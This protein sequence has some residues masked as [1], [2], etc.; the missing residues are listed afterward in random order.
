MAVESLDLA[1]TADSRYALAK[2]LGDLSDLSGDRRVYTWFGGHSFAVQ[3]DLEPLR[4]IFKVEGV[5]ISHLVDGDPARISARQLSLFRDAETDGF[6]SRWRNPFTT[7]LDEITFVEQALPPP[8]LSNLM[9]WFV[10]EEKAVAVVEHHREGRD[11]SSQ[12]FVTPLRELQDRSLTSADFVGTWQ[13][14]AAW[15]P[16]MEM[17]SMPGYIF[18]RMFMRKY[19]RADDLPMSL[20]AALRDRFPRGLE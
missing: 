7:N 12:Q 4:L 15:W 8:R 16:W 18:T 5:M 6:I 13:T 19:R 3:G 11:S 10:T 20:T 17:S 9:P 14:A 1:T 2:L